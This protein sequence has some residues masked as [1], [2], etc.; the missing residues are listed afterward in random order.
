M[1][2]KEQVR[3]ECIKYI[4]DSKRSTSAEE[5]SD[6]AKLNQDFFRGGARQWTEETYNIYK[7]KGVTPISINRCKPVVKGLLGMYL[8]SRQSVRVRPRRSGTGTVAGVWTELIKHT[9][10][11]SYAD[12]VYAATFLRGAI[13]TESYLKVVIDNAEN[14]NGQPK[15]VMRA[16][17]Q[18]SVDPNAKEYDLNESAQFVIDK[19]WQQRE[20]IMALYPEKEEEIKQGI[21]NLDS[22]S[23]STRLVNDMATWAA[24]ETDVDHYD[25]EDGMS[26]HDLLKTYRYLIHRVYWKETTPAL[27]VADTQ[28][29]K[30][31]IVT[32]EK[33]VAR[34]R[35]KKDK[36]VRFKITNYAAKTL[37]ESVLLG[38]RLLEDVPNPYGEGVSKYPIFR[39][40]PMWDDGYACGALDDVV[41][42]NREENIH[43]TQA[44]RLLNQLANSGWKVKEATDKKWLAILKDWGSVEGIVIDES[45]F[46]GKVE[47]I[48]PNPP[49]Q[50]HKIESSQFEQDIKR[51]SGVD[52]AIHGYNTGKV[53]SGIA[54]GRKQEQSKSSNHTYF[55]NFYRTLEIYGNFLLDILVENDYYTDEEILEIVGESG[56]MDVKML[57]KSHAMLVGRLGV[58]LQEP[59]MLPPLDPNIMMAVRPEDQPM[60]LQTVREGFEASKRY[61]Q[62]YPRLKSTWDE[63][64]KFNA[65]QM[66]ISELRS[67]TTGSYGVKVTVSPSAPTERLQRLAELEML[68]DKYGIVPPD[69]FI[70]AT[71]LPNKDEIKARMQQQAE[72]QAR[73]EQ[74]AQRQGAAA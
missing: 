46:G 30:L 25:D 58:D 26:D 35:R 3:I 37:H 61:E 9:E 43:R 71:D 24:G 45:K 20:E 38:N 10:D 12:Y 29:K 57:E 69:I 28:E 6:R 70:E 11:V 50:A 13:D 67:D 72:A 23:I 44:I 5:Q 18:V 1:L 41:S 60:V 31:A 8:E 68:Q 27:I 21:E 2:D 15:V 52:D 65:A 49:S 40:S 74:Q 56:L 39:Y 48:V 22:D 55:D 63:V 51:V 73:A 62:H 42:L 7:S 14:V 53:E 19:E 54:I 33:K 64:I 47:K 4:T 59:Q 16:L 32:D 34:I 36:S 17:N 66:L